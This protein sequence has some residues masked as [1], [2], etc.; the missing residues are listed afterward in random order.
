MEKVVDEAVR[1][2]EKNDVLLIHAA[3]NDGQN[4][5]YAMN[6]PNDEYAKKKLIAAC[7]NNNSPFHPKDAVKIKEFI[8]NTLKDMIAFS[9]IAGKVRF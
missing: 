6:F 4:N 9:P 3:G 8:R 5:D 2:A 7:V 1:Y